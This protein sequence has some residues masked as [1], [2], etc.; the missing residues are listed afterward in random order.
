MS[1][2][3]RQ[4]PTTHC[5]SSLFLGSA[6]IWCPTWILPLRE[7]VLPLCCLGP[8]PLGSP[9]AARSRKLPVSTLR[10]ACLLPTASCLSCTFPVCCI[11]FYTLKDP[12]NH[13]FVTPDAV[14]H[15]CLFLQLLTCCYSN[16]N[17]ANLHPGR[18]PSG[19]HLHRGCHSTAGD[20]RGR[21]YVLWQVITIWVLYSC[22]NST[23]GSL[24]C[25]VPSEL[26]CL[27]AH[28]T[29]STPWCPS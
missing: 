21:G 2:A 16:Y 4:S 15:T 19:V 25:Q 9:P 7:L 26:S 8:A 1:L 6:L 27:F 29:G 3:G 17:R 13:P 11:S 24:V 28:P 5:H 12:V 23:S 18:S 22:A 10:S 20:S 14:K